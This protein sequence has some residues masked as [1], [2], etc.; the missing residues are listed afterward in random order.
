MDIPEV[1]YNHLYILHFVYSLLLVLVPRSDQ[2][3]FLSVKLTSVTKK[4]TFDW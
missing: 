3:G 1:L 4:S 2:L